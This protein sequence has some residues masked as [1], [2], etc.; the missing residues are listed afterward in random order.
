MGLVVILAN[1]TKI[2]SLIE[3]VIRAVK[4]YKVIATLMMFC[5]MV[6][7][8]CLYFIFS[9][10]K[11]HEDNLR[12]DRLI[13]YVD[14]ILKDCKDKT[15]ITI[16]TVSIYQETSN[17]QHWPAKFKIARACDTRTSTSCIIDLQD[18]NPSLYREKDLEVDSS[19][20]ALFVNIGNRINSVPEHFHLRNDTGAQDL[21]SISFYPS[22]RLVIE[23]LDWF[24]EDI[25]HDLWIATILNQ[26]SDVLY[27]ITL[28]SAKPPKENVCFNY[29]SIII[30]LKEF[31]L[32]NNKF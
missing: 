6:I 4:G 18:K 9:D 11:I 15:A 21:K 23:E 10:N 19:S 32:F 29:D 30:K 31:I 25:I 22:I 14:S 26:N 3:S 13:I 27:V 24:K 5:L 20:Y 7:G 28:L 8:G 16:G 17:K 1:L 12:D 2:F